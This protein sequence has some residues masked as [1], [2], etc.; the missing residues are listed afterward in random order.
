M[1]LW[2][3]L[4]VALVNTG[5]PRG[6]MVTIYIDNKAYEVKPGK[7]LLNASLSLGFNLPYF[8]W[9]ES[10]GSIGACRQCAVTQFK[11]ENDTKGRIVMSCMTE[12]T[13]G[14][15]FSIDHSD[16][17]DFRKNVIEWMMINH[18]HDCPVCDEGGECHLQD[19]TVMTGHNYRKYRFQKRT[20]LNQ[21]LGPFIHHEMNRCITCY[22]C[23]RFYKDYA[24]GKDL[25]AFRSSN[26]VYF[27]RNAD[28]QLES[29][30]SGN[31]VEIC[32]TGVFTD[33][34]FRSQFVRKWDLQSSPAICQLCAVGCNI[35][36]QERGGILRRIT[37]RFS[38][39]VNGYFLCDKGRFGHNFINSEKRIR[40]SKKNNIIIP[41]EEA[42]KEFNS[43]VAN[44]KS[45]IGI[46]S[47]EASL[48]DN[49][50]LKNL[51]GEE[52]FYAGASEKNWDLINIIKDGL[53]EGP[54]E[55]ASPKDM[56]NSDA[57]LIIEEDVLK[58]A[59]RIFLNIL[60]TAYT[61]IKEN[62]KS[63]GIPYW[64]DAALRNFS[65]SQKLSVGQINSF[66]TKLDSI[67]QFS[68]RQKINETL[69]YL[70][71]VAKELSTN[72]LASKAAKFLLEAKRPIIVSGITSESEHLIKAS[73]NLAR[74]LKHKG[75][76]AKLYFI[77]PK[78]N[79]MG[80]SLL[81]AKNLKYF[82]KN[83]ELAVVL[84]N[85]DY[86]SIRNRVKNIVCMDF[87]DNGQFNF[88]DLVLACTSFAEESGTF[89]NN[90]GRAQRSYAVMPHSNN[91][92][93]AFRW[94]SGDGTNLDKIA[95]RMI[96]ENQIFSELNGL[97]KSNFL[98]NGQK[99]ARQYQGASG[100]TSIKANE[101]IHEQPPKKDPDSPLAFSME[102]QSK[103]IPADLLPRV[104]S[105]GWNSNQSLNM[106]QK[107]PGS[108]YKDPAIEI[109]LIKPSRGNP[110]KLFPIEKNNDNRASNFVKSK[111]D[112][113]ASL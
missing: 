44:A 12:A 21:K 81:G 98:I 83:C 100:R 60:Q 61:A 34:T 85:I 64:N 28:G 72:N 63:I 77:L 88:S 59:P 91:I 102:G 9:H 24:H 33:K 13:N 90:E 106:L 80:L 8:C 97:Y 108:E 22:R 57:V 41:K 74:I 79:S 112:L 94:C 6:N 17:K 47:E 56:E 25:N 46:G 54:N 87:I 40:E 101:N 37:N 109:L 14:I 86:K 103:S 110:I 55:I 39:N 73:F 82:N 5:L 7:N 51:V 75:I 70:L 93:E 18:P 84:K 29:E 23:V 16:A 76:D 27:G 38:S 36:A 2:N 105:P 96:T 71:E 3:I 62:G 50:A 95:E 30:F 45:I 53:L 92:D 78:S 43:L 69:P 107:E 26:Q 19:M 4:K 20:F 65:P 48:E 10:L 15:R 31:L 111:V 58:T 66:P 49:Y 99:I 68:L 32:P 11:D 42:R 104:W 1:I 89:V 35:F 113:G 52:N 67:A